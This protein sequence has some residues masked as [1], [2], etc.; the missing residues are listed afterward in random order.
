MSLSLYDT[1]ARQKRP[2]VPVDPQRVTMY[3][4]GPTVY[5]YAHIGNARPVVVFDVLFR[6]L[7]HTYGDD[8]VLYAANVT[9]VDD[10]INAK[11]QAEGVEIDV[12]TQRYLDIYNRDMATLG[13]LAPTFQPRATQTMDAIIEMI[14]RLVD[15]GAAYAAEGHV[16]FST[17]SYPDYGQLSGR[18]LE[19]MVAGAR[20]DVAPYKRNPA[21]FV[22]WKP[23]KAGEPVWDSPWGPGRP[24]WHIECSAMI[25]QTLGLPIDIH[26]GGNDLIFPHHENEL[27]QGV[28]AAHGCESGHGADY[29]RYWMHNGF[30]NFGSEKMSKS[31]GNVVLVHDL[32]KQT[33]G[34]AVRWALLVGHYRAP[35]EWSGEMLEQARKSLDRL[36]GAL[37]RAADVT[38]TTTAPGAKFLAALEDD[39]NTAQAMAELFVLASVIETGDE[40]ARAQAKGELLASGALLGFLQADPET[41]F[42]GGADPELKARVETLIADRIAARTAKDWPRADAIRDELNALNVVV[43]DSAEGATWRLKEPS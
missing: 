18:S 27:A 41:W 22:L 17:E 19:D 32:V 11:A 24:G 26:G 35:L 34:E 25:E 6:L 2:F 30:L 20:V 29:A 9:D 43:M 39:L 42:Q 3:V 37:R 31:L 5:N 36:Y 40:A 4:C 33:P 14:G 21:D 10:K 15:K 28:C 1:M 38:P 16:L 23:S 13:A 12:I 7:R 8:A